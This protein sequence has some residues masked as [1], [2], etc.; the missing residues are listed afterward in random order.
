MSTEETLP[1]IDLEVLKP[2]YYGM[3]QSI[4]SMAETAGVHYLDVAALAIRAGV[5]VQLVGAGP[6]KCAEYPA[7]LKEEIDNAMGVLLS[8]AADVEFNS[9][10]HGSTSVN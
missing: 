1:E 7:A 4:F 9:R 3:I 8:D 2:L 6:D 10:G 5:V